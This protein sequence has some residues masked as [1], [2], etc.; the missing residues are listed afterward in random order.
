[1]GKKENG[2]CGCVDRETCRGMIAARDEV[3]HRQASEIG[4]LRKEIARQH[5]FVLSLSSRLA[6][7]SEVLSILA[8][9][10]EYRNLGRIVDPIPL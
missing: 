2:V 9:R 3:I 4:E 10:K 5:Q 6:A 8:E 1:M 7:A